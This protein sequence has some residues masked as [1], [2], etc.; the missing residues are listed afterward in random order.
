MN[1]NFQPRG[2][3]EDVYYDGKPAIH[4]NNQHG[5]ANRQH[6]SNHS[7][8]D[9]EHIP[10]NN[11]NSQTNTMQGGPHPQF[12]NQGAFQQPNQMPNDLQMTPDQ[13]NM[14]Q[15]AEVLRLRKEAEDREM[16]KF[17]RQG[18]SQLKKEQ[19]KRDVREAH[20]KAEIE[21]SN[22]YTDTVFSDLSNAENS[23]A[24]LRKDTRE[25]LKET[26][27]MGADM[28][29]LREHVEQARREKLAMDAEFAAR[30]KV[31]MYQAPVFNNS[32][33]FM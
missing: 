11:E 33:D 10:H 7:R 32:N 12:Q 3:Q 24:D 9:M 1:K 21:E 18:I 13:L 30:E 29:K 6:E 8:M 22:R 20:R 25:M 15:E 28:A 31:Q 26:A 2:D 17:Y 4:Q 27:A 16:A 14:R 5:D 19:E 23:V